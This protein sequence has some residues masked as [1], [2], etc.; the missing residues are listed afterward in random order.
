MEIFGELERIFATSL[1]PNRIPIAIGMVAVV[2]ALL[3]VAW[4]RRW[5]RVARRHPR[6]TAALVVLALVVGLPSAWYLG[7]PLIIRTE[8]TEPVGGTPV[9]GA[10]VVT[11]GT[12]SGA[13]DFHFG[14]GTASIVEVS[15]GTYALRFD[16]FSV[17]NGPDLYVYLS[18]DAAGYVDGAVE[19]GILKATDGSFGYELPA[20]LDPAAFRSVVIWCRQ[21]AVQ[22]AAAPLAP[23]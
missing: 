14:S 1:Y 4:R 9:D 20:G 18:P 6:T 15:S 23:S 21:F 11:S 16:D 12:I 3:V 17:R 10:R 7:S 8:L 5:D 2:V 19:I 22:F 13:D